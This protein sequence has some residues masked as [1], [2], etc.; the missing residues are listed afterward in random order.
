MF[1]TGARSNSLSVNVD[2]KRGWLTSG[3]YNGKLLD[4]EPWREE[5]VHGVEENEGR[6]QN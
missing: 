2:K 6:F 1:S 5:L 4:V 3:Q